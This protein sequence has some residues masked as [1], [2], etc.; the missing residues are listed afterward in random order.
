MFGRE[1]RK[2]GFFGFGRVAHSG[3]EASGRYKKIRGKVPRRPA[4]GC[5]NHL[6]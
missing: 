2:S 4:G 6:I 1:E 3:T 5:L